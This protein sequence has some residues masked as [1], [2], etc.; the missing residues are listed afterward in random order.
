MADS[1]TKR[2]RLSTRDIQSYFTA[3]TE[4]LT[5]RCD[6][7]SN[8]PQ[9][10]TDLDSNELNQNQKE[11]PITSETEKPPP[12]SRLLVLTMTITKIITNSPASM[13]NWAP[14]GQILGSI[15]M[16]DPCGPFAGISALLE[17]T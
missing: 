7:E 14:R 9:S 12:P 4:K 10:Y 6:V 8:K 17:T 1:D 16:W 2:K 11:D 3:L 15:T 13:T 5:T